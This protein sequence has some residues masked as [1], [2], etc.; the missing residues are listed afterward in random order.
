M[1]NRPSIEINPWYVLYTKPRQEKKTA[2]LLRQN[3][4]EAYCPIRIELKQWSDRKK[5]VETPLFNS[6]IFVNVQE[7]D[8]TKVLSVPGVVQFVFWCGA[9]A[10]VKN[11][12][13]EEIK[14]WLNEYE[15]DKITIEQFNVSD[16]VKID[17]GSFKN[18]TGIIIKKNGN[19]VSLYIESL[20][21]VIRSKIPD[22]L[23]ER[24]A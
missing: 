3:G 9:P 2:L 1:F 11:K 12:E 20:G 4:F 8:R 17:S 22:I 10:V 23:L 21:L 14:K 24:T 7:K 6:Y 19:Q 18:L 13:I 5:L 16:K 15:H